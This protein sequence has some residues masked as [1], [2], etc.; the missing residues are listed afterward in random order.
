M[1]TILHAA[2]LR[3]TGQLIYCSN[4]SVIRLGV[5]RV[6]FPGAPSLRRNLPKFSG[7]PYSFPIVPSGALTLPGPA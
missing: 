3:S 6:R 5:G 4:V 2:R 7:T 1:E